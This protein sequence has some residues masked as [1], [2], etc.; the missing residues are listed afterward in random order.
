[1]DTILILGEKS[2]EHVELINF[3]LK[4]LGVETFILDS[5]E[6]PSKVSISWDPLSA[7]GEI[8]NQHQQ[9][10]F[11]EIK[12]VYWRTVNQIHISQP[13]EQAQLSML[14]IDSNS[15][16]RTLLEYEQINWVNSW[17]AYQFHKVKPRQLALAAQLGASV[18]KSVIGNNKESIINF[19]ENVGNAIYKPVHGGTHTVRITKEMLITSMTATV[20]EAAPITVQEFIAGTNVRT[21]VLGNKVYS[22]EFYSDHTDYR[23]DKNLMPVC[24]ET[25]A[26]IADLARNLTRA[27]GMRW[28]AIDWR[29]TVDEK[30][31]FLEAN[32]SPMF[33]NFEKLTGIPV[34]SALIEL[35]TN[36]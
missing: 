25:P 1:M 33:I 2:D 4:S 28:T 14:T 35:L 26:E 16:L 15:M 31:Y 32:P 13:M 36:S 9:V 30:Y 8:S 10:K 21:Y 34:T 24:C 20:L 29:K 17:S 6:Y 19:L 22:A 7:E 18:P 27:F 12:S 11:S 5:S 3:Q 23:D